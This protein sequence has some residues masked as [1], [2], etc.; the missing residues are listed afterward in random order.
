MASS[1]SGPSGCTGGIEIGGAF[2]ELV[3]PSAILDGRSVVIHGIMPSQVETKPPIDEVLATFRDYVGGAVL[4]GHCLSIDLSFLNRE[5]RRLTGTPFR[6]PVVD[7]LSLYGWLRHRFPEAQAFTAT[8]PGLSLFDLAH[9]FDIPVEEG[10]TALG[11][12]YITAQLFQRF[13][14]LLAEAGVRDLKGLLRV[15]DPERQAENFI[16]P[17]G[18]AHF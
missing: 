5:A 15:G 11:D 13:L 18:Q 8:L 7:T 16:G 6:N 3:N 12:A 9:L 14:P 2:H 1:P 17:G 10:H 4:V